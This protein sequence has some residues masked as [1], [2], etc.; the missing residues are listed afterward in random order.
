MCPCCCAAGSID[1]NDTSR[2]I[3][4]AASLTSAEDTVLQGILETLSVPERA[5]LVL[6]LLKKEVELCKL[7]ADIRQQVGGG[8]GFC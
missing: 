8:A 1:L 2:L 7:Q 3:D 4:A 5:R 6:E